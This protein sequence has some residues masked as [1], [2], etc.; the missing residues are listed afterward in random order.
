MRAFSSSAI[1][2]LAAFV[3]RLPR[4]SSSCS[5]SSSESSE[6]SSSAE[7][8]RSAGVSSNSICHPETLARPTMR[9]CDL[10]RRWLEMAEADE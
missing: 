9:L 2:L 3:F 4:I 10:S 1:A 7:R 5:R 6:S 8:S